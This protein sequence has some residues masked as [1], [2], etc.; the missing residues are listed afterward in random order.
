MTFILFPGISPNDGKDGNGLKLESCANLYAIST[1]NTKKFIMSWIF[2][3]QFIRI[4]LCL[5]KTTKY[6]FSE[7]LTQSNKID[8]T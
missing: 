8:V 2:T 5:S 4:I 7:K 1:K 3:S 6:N